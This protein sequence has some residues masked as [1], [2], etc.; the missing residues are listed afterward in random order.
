MIKDQEKLQLV[1]EGKANFHSFLIPDECNDGE[2]E[3]SIKNWE[4]KQVP[5]KSM[6]V[7]F[8]PHMLLNRDLSILVINTYLK[9]ISGPVRIVDAMCGAGIRG[10]RYLLETQHDELHVDFVDLNPAAIKVCKKNLKL[11]AIDGSSYDVHVSDANSFLYAHSQKEPDRFHVIDIDP[12]GNPMIFLSAGLKAGAKKSILQINATDL[13]VLSGLHREATKRKYMTRPMRNITYHAENAI[14]ML[15]GAT[16]RKAAELDCAIIPKISIARRHYIKV[17]VEKIRG[18]EKANECLK[19]LGYIIHCRN[20]DNRFTVSTEDIMNL[21]ECPTCGSHKI[22]HSGPTWI[23]LIQD[24]DF[25][26]RMLEQLDTLGYLKSA[27]KIQKMVSLCKEEAEMP[28]TS[29]DIHE[30]ANKLVISPPPLDVLIEQLKEGGFKASRTQSNPLAIKTDA[31][32]DMI[33]KIM[34]EQINN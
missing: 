13:A 32:R 23:G 31:K 6:P 29:D 28:P 20:C 30:I 22:D 10:I 1:K 27:K 11:N 14:R 26:A 3:E 25:C 7:F 12:F 24:K 2:E 16:L 4:K 15:L 21:H 9:E 18:A 17:I 33:F 8:N 5:S 19:N 34:K